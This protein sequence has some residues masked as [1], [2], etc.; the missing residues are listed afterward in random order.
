[1]VLKDLEQ[2][3]FLKYSQYLLPTF[4]IFFTSLLLIRKFGWLRKMGEIDTKPIESVQSALSLFGEKGDQRKNR[5]TGSDV[6]D[7]FAVT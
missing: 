3:R 6:R 1:M 4:V 7:P 2:N 5:S